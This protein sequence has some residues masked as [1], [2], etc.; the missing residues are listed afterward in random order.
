MISQ[1]PQL[2][3]LELA[4]K[5]SIQRLI[6]DFPPY[7]DFNFTSLWSWNIHNGIHISQLNGNLVVLFSDY[8]TNEKF[9][10]FIG[11][12][13]VLTTA[14]E[15]ISYSKKTYQKNFLKLLPEELALYFKFK[16]S[17]FTV[18][19]D[20][21]AADYIYLAEHL[22]TMP[23]WRNSSKAKGLK[24]HLVG[25]PKYKVVVSSMKTIDKAVYHKMF[26]KWSM[27]KHTQEAYDLNEFKAFERFLKLSDTSIKFIS[28]YVDGV[29][30]GFS[31]YEILAHGYAIAHFSKADT[32]D[33]HG[34]YDI[35]NWEEGRVLHKRGVK[36][37]NWEQDLGIEGLRYSKEKYKPLFLMKKI[38]VTLA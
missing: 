26:H 37:L 23:E 24:K 38:M 3:T 30:A 22:A 15:L 34:I 36:F 21:D 8:V 12:S 18:H 35:L 25:F 10:S 17:P 28:I 4:D 14:F 1:F 16:H 13:E 2:K 27:K 19:T 20:R 5:R 6:K 32:E 9:L 7:S 31:A 29:L 11:C 33:Y